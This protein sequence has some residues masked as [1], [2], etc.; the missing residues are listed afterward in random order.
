MSGKSWGIL[1]GM[2]TVLPVCFPWQQGTF[3]KGS[4]SRSLPEMRKE[5]KLKMAVSFP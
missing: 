5:V 3:K 2:I 4:T 1:R